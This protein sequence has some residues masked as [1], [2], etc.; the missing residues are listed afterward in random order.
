MELLS[1]GVIAQGGGIQLRTLLFEPL[2]QIAHDLGKQL[3]GTEIFQFVY[4]QLLLIGLLLELLDPG[5]QIGP[6]VLQ[7]IDFRRELALSGNFFTQL[8]QLLL[9][10]VHMVPH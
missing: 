9:I 3:G 7:S 8:I 5:G 2:V 4:V 1:G 6:L 10:V